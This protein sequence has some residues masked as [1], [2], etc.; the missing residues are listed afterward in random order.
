M[1]CNFLRLIFLLLYLFSVAPPSEAQQQQ[2]YYVH[3]GKNLRVMGEGPAQATYVQ[4]QIW[5]YPEHVHIPH[6]AAGLPYSRWGLIEGRS[7]E[8]VIEQL[9]TFQGFERAYLNFFGPTSGARTRI[10]IRLV[11]LQ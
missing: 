11:R 10:S 8:I 1:K 2:A 9:E 7:A 5:L 4:W 3:D 6:H